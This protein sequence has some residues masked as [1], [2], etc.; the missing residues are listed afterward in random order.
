MTEATAKRKKRRHSNWG[1]VR[2]GAGRPAVLENA[3][4]LTVRVPGNHLKELAV[5][6]ESQGVSLVDYVRQVIKGHLEETR[7]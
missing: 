6:A 1:G 2:P 4:R 3:G 5:L 7:R